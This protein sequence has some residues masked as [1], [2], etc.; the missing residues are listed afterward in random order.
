M[1][2]SSYMAGLFFY[3]PDYMAPGLGLLVV[4][5]LL[6]SHRLSAYA[7][8]PLDLARDALQ[9]LNSGAL[10]NRLYFSEA[11][12]ELGQTLT[13]LNS[14]LDRLEDTLERQRRFV[15]SVSHDIRTPLTIIRG[16]IEVALLRERDPQEYQETLISNLEEV[17]R[18]TKLVEDLLTLARADYGELGLSVNSVRLEPLLTGVKD[19]FYEQALARNL[20]I[21]LHCQEDPVIEGDSMRLRQLF[22]NLLENAVYYTLEK[23]EIEISL[24]TDPDE[25]T[26]QVLFKDT[27]IGIDEKDL[28]HIFEPFYRSEDSRTLRHQGYGLGL[29][30]CES[31]IK[32]HQGKIKV[33][34][35]K[36]G[37]DSGTTFI[38]SLPLPSAGLMPVA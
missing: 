36:G 26:A 2:V 32:A 25:R 10:N 1:L 30:I 22:S 14:L 8:G 3:A 5:G 31:I 29:A 27:G 20:E 34:S 23:G 28:P 7:L 12:D 38:I 9:R 16:D 35:Q 13:A 37:K 21:N 11:D 15:G 19:G 6:A 24:F 4:V 33:E 17:E 18:I